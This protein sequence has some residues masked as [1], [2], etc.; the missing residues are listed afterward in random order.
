V[1]FEQGGEPVQA[2]RVGKL[3]A[4]DEAGVRRRVIAGAQRGQPEQ[5]GGVA[6][7]AVRVGEQFG[8]RGEF[9]WG[10]QLGAPRWRDGR[11]RVAGYV[12]VLTS[13]A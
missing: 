4:G 6:V 5:G 3:A 12:I 1:L 9:E 13:S 8:I 11:S 7:A 2:G 10:D